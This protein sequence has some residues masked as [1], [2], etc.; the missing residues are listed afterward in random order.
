MSSTCGLGPSRGAL[1]AL[2]GPSG[3]PRQGRRAPEEGPQEGA[4]RAPRGPRQGLMAH[5]LVG[6]PSSKPKKK[7]MKY[8]RRWCGAL[9]GPSWGHIGALLGP[10]WRL[11]VTQDVYG[12]SV[13]PFPPASLSS[14][15][16]FSS[17][18]PSPSFSTSYSSVSSSS[19]SFY[20]SSLFSPLPHPSSQ[21]PP[22]P[23]FARL[24]YALINSTRLGVVPA[25]WVGGETRS[26][27]N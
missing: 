10:S 5:V 3:P 27:Q 14:P 11:R 2:L 1:A 26:V 16:D 13:R 21:P 22:P 9:L 23:S 7:H 12:F 20:A 17:S 15:S 4:R 24:G 18:C 6:R 8:T 19:A 25:G